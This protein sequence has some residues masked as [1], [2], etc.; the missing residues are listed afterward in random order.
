VL[1]YALFPHAGSWQ[2]AN[3]P[4][5]ALE[6]A[7]PL[8]LSL[9]SAPP[10]DGS[11]DGLVDQAGL[12]HVDAD[13]VIAETVKTAWDNRRDDDGRDGDGRDVVVRLYEAHNRRGTVTLTLDRPIRSASRTDLDENDL[14]PLPVSGSSVTFAV[15]PHELVTLRLRT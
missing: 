5:R 3:V 1:R 6:L 15:R 11:S 4:R 8:Q 2:D 7:V 13:H 10:R 9:L 14:G 12:L